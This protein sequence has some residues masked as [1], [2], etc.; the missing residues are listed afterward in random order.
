MP[1]CRDCK[2]KI[3]FVM[4]DGKWIPV[5]NYEIDTTERMSRNQKIPIPFEPNKHTRHQCKNKPKPN[6]DGVYRGD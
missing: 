3:Q 5:E 4:K 6:Y 1:S 2:V